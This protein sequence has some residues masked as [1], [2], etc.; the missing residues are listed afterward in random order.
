MR[1]FGTNQ[2]NV[3]ALFAPSPFSVLSPVFPHSIL[4]HIHSYI[5]PSIHLWILAS[6]HLSIHLSV[7]F[8]LHFT[9]YMH[10][11]IHPPIYFP[12][13]SSLPVIWRYT[14]SILI[15]HSFIYR[16]FP[17]NPN[18]KFI[19]SR[20]LFDMN[21]QFYELPIQRMNNIFAVL[22]ND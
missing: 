1:I 14:E 21:F 17:L 11:S 9:F 4:L 3:L 10:P 15:I 8:S 16:F 13:S 22:S 5:H 7:P 20:I 6:I 2:S 18:W 12:V 19:A